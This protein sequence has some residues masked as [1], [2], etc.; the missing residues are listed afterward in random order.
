MTRKLMAFRFPEETRKALI[1]ISEG[2]TYIDALTEAINAALEQKIMS[3]M[4]EEQKK[5]VLYKKFKKEE[6]L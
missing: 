4:V 2:R 6:G 3:K 1:F 5:R